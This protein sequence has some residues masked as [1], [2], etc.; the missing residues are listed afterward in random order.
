VRSEAEK[1]EAEALLQRNKS[2]CALPPEKASF[3]E[4]A[5]KKKMGFVL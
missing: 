5:A 3:F 1:E 2:L 4:E